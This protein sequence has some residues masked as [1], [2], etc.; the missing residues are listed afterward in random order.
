[1]QEQMIDKAG[2]AQRAA[3]NRNRAEKKG[4]TLKFQLVALVIMVVL[5]TITEF[6]LDAI[7]YKVTGTVGYWFDYDWENPVKASLGTL[8]PTLMVVCAGFLA[9]TL[10]MKA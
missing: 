10:R 5:Y 6:N 9:F 1:M 4:I 8:K 7:I 3:D 2:M